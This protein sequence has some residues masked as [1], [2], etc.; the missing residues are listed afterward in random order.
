[1]A[2]VPAQSRLVIYPDRAYAFEGDIEVGDPV[3]EDVVTSI[4][5]GSFLIDPGVIES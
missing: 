2:D 4:S 3:R 1:M 5:P